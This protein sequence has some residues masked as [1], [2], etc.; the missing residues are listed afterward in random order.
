MRLAPCVLGSGIA[1]SSLMLEVCDGR[2]VRALRWIPGLAVLDRIG[3][4]GLLAS[5]ATRGVVGIRV[6]STASAAVEAAG[7]A[8]V[9]AGAGD[10]SVEVAG[11][12]LV[13]NAGGVA[14]GVAIE[15][16]AEAAA[17]VDVGGTGASGDA[18]LMLAVG[19]VS[20]AGVAGTAVST[21]GVAG[22]GVAVV[23][24]VSRARR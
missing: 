23:G 12:G 3:R 10:V 16:G 19:G 5:R 13:P 21:A 17:E 15:S 18:V 11:E 20:T 9:G 2:D 14:A 6:S 7:E 4:S 24:W 1:P 22:V 8:G